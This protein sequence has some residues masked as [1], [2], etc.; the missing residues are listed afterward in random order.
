ME[1]IKSLW[2]IAI[3]CQEKLVNERVVQLLLQLHTN[4]DFGMEKLIPLYEN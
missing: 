4:V 3:D 1:A 2:K